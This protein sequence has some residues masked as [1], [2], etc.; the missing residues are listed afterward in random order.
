MTIKSDECT[1]VL[2]GMLKKSISIK[3]ITLFPDFANS[4]TSFGIIAKAVKNKL[5]KFSAINL[6]SF[7][8][9]R[10]GTVDDRPY[11]GGVGMVLRSDVLEKAIRKS[12]LKINDLRLKKQ[13][14]I[15][16]TPQ[17]K[18]F[19]Q[20]DAHRLAKYDE[21]VFVSGRYEGFDE[22]VRS[23]VDEELSVGDYV[24][25]GGELPA[26]VI[27]EA[28]IRLIPGII[29]KLESTESES[30]ADGLL[31]YPQYTKP[32]VLE[33]KDSRL[34][35]KELRVPKVL[36]SGNHQKIAE[37]RHTEAVKKTKKRRPDLLS[38]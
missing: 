5:L 16:L 30:F 37:W 27:T 10:R 12:R 38:I 11:G 13:R 9:D 22:R 21:L 25:M 14:V 34:R 36:L 2:R 35:I 24:L 20:A 23:F 19:T 31:E 32:E 3:V 28:V 29:G 7:G 26:L 17:G 4:Y 15:L 6:R 33:I 8:L 18:R 1:E